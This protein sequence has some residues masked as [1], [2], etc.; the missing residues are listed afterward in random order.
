MELFKYIHKNL[1]VV[2]MKTV[3]PDL[4]QRDSPCFQGSI[5]AL[6]FYLTQRCLY[7]KLQCTAFLSDAADRNLESDNS[8]TLKSRRRHPEG[9]NSF[10]R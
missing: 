1:F 8:V 10:I 6:L 4:L 7:S 5:L 3:M 9:L 2:F